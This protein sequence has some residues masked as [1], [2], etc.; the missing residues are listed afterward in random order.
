[1]VISTTSILLDIFIYALDEHQITAQ[2]PFP[3]TRFFTKE[4]QDFHFRRLELYVDLH[5]SPSGPQ[6]PLYLLPFPFAGA[7]KVPANFI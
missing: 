3:I 7:G 6:S 1:M 4:G 2:H 5:L